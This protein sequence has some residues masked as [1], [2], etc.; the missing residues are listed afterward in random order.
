MDYNLLNKNTLK[1]IESLRQG[2][3]G[4]LYFSQIAEQSK[5]KS[6]NNLLKNLN[7][8]SDSKILVK[9]QFKGNTFYSLNYSNP[10]SI[11][12]LH[13]IDIIRFNALVFEKRKPVQEIIQKIKP[14]LAVIFG[15][16]A[17]GNFNKESDIDLLLISEKKPQLIKEISSRYNV[18]I[19]PVIINFEELDSRNDTIAH[20]LKTGYPLVG[21]EYFYEE[22][23]KI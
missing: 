8:L 15:S 19:S 1:I 12:I 17:K 21:E 10:L 16:T 2:K 6:R 4:R 5:I 3:Q 14:S 9:E 7:L 11:S 18:K 22:Y 13:I 20:I 23:K